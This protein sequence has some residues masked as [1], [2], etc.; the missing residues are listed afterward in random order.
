M[1]IPRLLERFS[2]ACRIR[3]FFLAFIWCL[4]LMLGA[5]FAFWSQNVVASLMCMVPL[6]RISIVG[7]GLVIL[8][9]LFLSAAA[10]IF[11]VPDLVYLFL[12]FDGFSFGYCLLGAVFAFG[13]AGWLV[14]LLISFSKIL[15]TV[16]RFCFFTRCIL[17]RS[18]AWPKFF[19]VI[20]VALIVCVFDYFCISQFLTQI[21]F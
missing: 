11:S 20:A 4:S 1:N 21:V 16:P 15:L 5:L 3:Q 17:V 19:C 18:I 7:L 2:S 8:F 13:S 9:P 10:V 14:L 6:C 12:F